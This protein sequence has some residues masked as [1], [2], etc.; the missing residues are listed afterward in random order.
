[1]E[2]SI[3]SRKRYN[4]Y[5]LNLG[6]NIYMKLAIKRAEFLKILNFVN[7]VIPAKSPE[8]QFL[9]FL[10]TCN[11]DSL[12]VTASDGTISTK[13]VQPLKDKDGKDVIFNIEPGFIQVPARYFLDI[14]SKIGGDVVTLEMVD[15]TLLNVSDE[16][17]NFNLKT[18]DGRE[19]PDVNLSVMENSK[20]IKVD[21]NDFRKLFDATSFAAATR[22]PKELFQG[23]NVRAANGKLYFLATDSYR[24][25]RYSVPLSDS[26]IELNFTCPVKALDMVSKIGEEGECQIFFD[27][28]SAIFISDNVT[29]ST[30]LIR[31]EFPSADRIIP[32]H[33]D[34]SCSINTQEFLNAAD[35]IKIVSSIE[36]KNCHAKLLLSRNGGAELTGKSAN[37]GDGKS[38]LQGVNVI[39]PEG[40]DVFEIGFNVDFVVSAVKALNSDKITFDFVS[41]T[42]MFMIKNDDP[43]NIQI[44]TP[45]RMNSFEN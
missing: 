21:L 12:S 2:L 1:M 3:P 15:S 35:L 33:F 44:V 41:P 31:G 39:L 11:E 4:I 16:V 18:K 9:N 6:D 42:R 30:R 13:Y 29:L 32:T 27:E 19:Y 5:I 8:S 40:Q 23:I 24:M 45:I 38:S 26:E 36:N 37:Y 14:V 10:L 20:G 34:Y 43:E 7:Q 17:N 22:G 28:Q 25:A